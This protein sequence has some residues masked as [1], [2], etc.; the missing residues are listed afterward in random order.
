[1]TGQLLFTQ[2]LSHDKIS[3]DGNSRKAV[4]KIK[5]SFNIHKCV[6]GIFFVSLQAE[7]MIKRKNNILVYCF[8]VLCVFLVSTGSSVVFGSDIINTKIVSYSNTSKGEIRTLRIKYANSD[9][10]E[11]PILYLTGEKLSDKNQIEI[12][13][14]ELSHVPHYYSYTLL[15]LNS[16]N[17]YSDLLKSEYIDGDYTAEITD[18]DQSE[19]TQQLYTH[20]RFMFPNDN[21]NVKV[22][23]NYAIKIYED[24]N[25]DEPIA[26]V[27]FSVVEPIVSIDATI[28]GNTDIEL[29]GRYQQLDIDIITKD[30]NI[31]NA[32]DIRL[33]VMQNGRLDNAVY[34]PRPT[35]IEG[36]RLRYINQRALIFEGGNEYRYF[37]ISSE[38]IMGHNVDRIYF[39]KTY[40]HAYL[41]ADE[42]LS[43]S[44]YIAE[45]DANGQY[46][47]N[48]ERKSEDDYEADY[49]WVHFLLP[50]DNIWFDGS[51]YINGDLTLHAMD[52]DS[53]MEYD[54]MHKCYYKSLYLKQG[55]YSYQYLFR[56]KN[57]YKGTTL[58]TE[59]S[60]WQT[61]NEYSILVYYRP[62]GSRAD[63]L[64]GYALKR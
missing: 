51:L 64:V 60:H 13:F 36:N 11:R 34:N 61:E 2:S 8:S 58:R 4:A 19:N 54:D 40:L 53:R 25:E 63:R 41:F 31:R 56:P 15:H 47:I 48:V 45:Q 39:D 50:Q 43:Q 9:V 5:Q 6:F 27:C 49:M 46:V 24:N 7:S 3:K 17:R 1:M 20:Y 30:L 32:E 21:M 62:F 42:N 29:S 37:D 16:D 12:S 14:D 38:Y 26:F 57:E 52:Y 44:P 22:S 59:G 33:I 10:L 28:R 55:A 35:Y 23:G 18:F